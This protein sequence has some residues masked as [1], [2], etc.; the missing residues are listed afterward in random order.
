MAY[1]LKTQVSDNNVQDFLYGISDEEKK[2]DCFKLLDLLE[3][4]S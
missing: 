4:I 3:A 1:T 2:Q